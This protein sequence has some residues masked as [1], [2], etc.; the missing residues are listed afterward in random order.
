MNGIALL[1]LVFL[2]YVFVQRSV[3][4]GALPARPG[5][6]GPGFAGPGQAC[7]GCSAVL[8]Q[9]GSYANLGMPGLARASAW[10]G[11]AKPG[12]AGLGAGLAKNL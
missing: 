3:L 2:K 1:A 11:L 4:G 10:P 12:Q 8:G 9:A 6:A 7:R 5:L